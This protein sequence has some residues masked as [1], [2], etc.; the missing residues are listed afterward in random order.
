M[1]ERKR[2]SQI[3]ERI[4]R[5]TIGV[6]GDFC[7]D[8]Y[9][10]LDA[11][12]P[13]NSIETGKPTSAVVQQRY[14]LGGAGNIVNNLVEL[15]VGSVYAFGV[16]SNDMFGREMLKQLRR[17]YNERPADAQRV[18]VRG[19]IIQQED[20]DTPLYAKP[21]LGME[22]QNRI[23]FGRFNII[24]EK[25]GQELIA[26]LTGVLSQLHALII[27]QQLPK[28][29]YSAEIVRALNRLA[30]EQ[31]EKIFLLDSRNRSDEFQNMI[32]KVNA[33][34][35]ARISGEQKE[36]NEFVSIDDLRR[37]AQRILR[38]PQKA[39]FI[40]RSGRGIL[41]GDGN[42][43]FEVPGIQILKKTDPVGAGDTAVSAIAA[44]LALGGSLKEAGL[45]GN[46]ASAV[47]VQKLQ[48]TGTA[49]PGEILE[50][51]ETADYVFRPE[52]ADDAR[53]AV[54]VPHTE[55]EIVNSET[56]WGQ[57]EHA[58]FDHDGTVSTLRQGWEGIME[59]VMVRS[60]LGEKYREVGEEMYRRVLRRVREYVDG[61][62]GIET[63]RQMHAL[64][65]MVK[66]F[67]FIP[68]EKIL[69]AKGY[70]Q[71]YNDE[72]MQ[73]VNSRLR[74]LRRGEL[75]LSDCTVKGAFK[76]LKALKERGVK[77]YLA[78][79]TDR[80][81]VIREAESLGYVKF[82]EGR[83]Y[84]SSGEIT[85]NT[86]RIVVE[87]IIRQNRLHGSELV[88]F[89]DG[90][91]ELREAKRYGGIAVGVASDEVRRY[92]LNATKRSRLVKAGA[93]VV[94]PDFSQEEKLLKLLFCENENL[95]D[96][97]VS[98][99]HGCNV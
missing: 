50:L 36:F 78:S 95:D 46:L 35:A 1:V 73:L 17:D 16:I 5:T 25:T 41:L 24:T 30:I 29:I 98:I 81:D 58:I 71:T 47:T 33:C 64:V 96:S 22:E 77:L 76:F 48:Q 99:S 68:E 31:P 62:T 89:G 34:E 9:W 53:H 6:I 83:I 69:P 20:W 59:P 79:G 32:C 72:L 7:L 18:N 3:L 87:T 49:G 38:Q 90:P 23:D 65:E 44:V 86:K 8:A 52:L 94:I 85:E 74:K 15:G 19:M 55:I 28:G 88:C 56:P 82:F 84:G 2:L 61:S 39:V 70:K 21:Y 14:S 51:A 27:N 93:D 43:F 97:T 60:I 63:I 4:K 54:F 92:G 42:G 12:P 66:E 91:V 80:E 45:I 57:I 13:E 37:Y 26:S 75:D 40:T 67:G 11:K 10:L